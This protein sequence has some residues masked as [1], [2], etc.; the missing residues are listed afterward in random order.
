MI[1][2]PILPTMAMAMIKP[3]SNHSSRPD[4]SPT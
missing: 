3:V 4:T 1:D 2:P